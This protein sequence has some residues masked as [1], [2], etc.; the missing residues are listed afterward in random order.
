MSAEAL[1]ESGHGVAFR[2]GPGAVRVRADRLGR[3]DKRVH[4]DVATLSAVG[5]LVRNENGISAPDDV[6]QTD[7]DLRAVA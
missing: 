4:G 3:D 5:L 1:A 7:F 2:M 6:I